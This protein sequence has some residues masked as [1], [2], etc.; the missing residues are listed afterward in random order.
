MTGVK[1]RSRGF[2]LLLTLLSAMALPGAQAPQPLTGVVFDDANGNGRLDAGERGLAGVVVSN[3][4]EVVKTRADGT[5]QLAGRG[6]GVVFVSVPDDYRAV[7]AF[8]QPAAAAGDAPINFALAPHRAPAEFSFIHA[9]D[10]H[11]SAENVA[12][13]RQLRGIVESRRPDFVLVTGDLVRDALR[14]G[15]EEARGYFDLYLDEI[16]QFPVPVWNVPGNHD[17]FGIERHLSHVSAA[18]PL[19][20]KAMYRQRLGPTYYSFTYG[21]IHFVGLDS[22]DIADEW[23]YG[24]VDDAQLAWLRADLAQVPGGTPVVTFNHIPFLSAVDEMGG[25]QDGGPAPTLLKLG[26]RTVFRH[27]VSNFADVLA[28]MGSRDWPLALGGHFHTRESIRYAS[29]VTTRF[30][31]TA[32]VTGPTSNAVPAISGVTL[33]R[34]SNKVIDAGEFIRLP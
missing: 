5:Y 16:R 12:R 10:T 22:V 28:V 3:Q 30:E 23:Y 31:L 7:G 14:V 24:H 32:A 6:A 18:H 2:V 34:V 8:W 4:H 25:Y 15:E 13:L 19:Y 21:G 17:N 27:V 1:F 33:Y 9:S 29:S 11:V 20:G 26:D